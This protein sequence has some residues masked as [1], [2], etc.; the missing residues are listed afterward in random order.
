MKY[1]F[2]WLI[3]CYQL[4]FSR[5][6]PNACRFEPSCSWYMYDAI[7][8]HGVLRGG[9]LGLRRLLRCRPGGGRGY[10]PVPD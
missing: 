9:S 4:T 10:D 3:R 2:L 6:M 5:L 7:D 8:R 1:P